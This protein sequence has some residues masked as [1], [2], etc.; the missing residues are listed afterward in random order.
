ML[1]IPNTTLEDGY[2]EDTTWG[3]T[4]LGG[5][6][7]VVANNPA[8]V[9]I[10]IG[11]QGQ[12]HWSEEQYCP[13]GIYPVGAGSPPSVLAGIR[14]RN[15]IAGSDAQFFGSFAYP[16]EAFIGSSSAFDSF[17]APSGSVGGVGELD[18]QQTVVAV[19]VTVASTE[20]AP[21]TLLT[22]DPIIFDG[23]G[24][25]LVEW[26]TP[27]RVVNAGVTGGAVN[28]WDSAGPTDLGRL[29]SIAGNDVNQGQAI[30]GSRRFTPPAG[31]KTYSLRAWATGATINL[32]AG[33][34]GVG[35]YF[36]MWGRISRIS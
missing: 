2:T 14:A 32:Q 34:G 33:A 17:I 24:S 3:G 6:S 15:F 5:G 29:A 21:L 26:Y 30:Y 35:T 8:A 19:N 11:E 9:Q 12:Q 4:R 27:A 18:Y 16:G 13:P 23:V 28:L 36:P 20:L 25:V 1:T 7:F 22:F 10:A 31:T